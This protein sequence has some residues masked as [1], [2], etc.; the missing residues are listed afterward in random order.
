M[1]DYKNGH[2]NDKISLNIFFIHI[3]IKNYIFVI[4]DDKNDPIRKLK[5][6]KNILVWFKKKEFLND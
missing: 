4:C 3:Y 5:W 1:C 2:L 6:M